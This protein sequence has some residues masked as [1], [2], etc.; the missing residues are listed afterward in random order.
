MK[1]QSALLPD[2]D[3]TS[4]MPEALFSDLKDPRYLVAAFLMGEIY[5]RLSNVALF[6]EMIQKLRTGQIS[7]WKW[8]G[9]VFQLV[10]DQSACTV[11]DMEALE[12][13]DL[14]TVVSM[15]HDDLLNV[16]Q[17][18]RDYVLGFGLPTH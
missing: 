12:N 7:G 5:L 15:S 10:I 13:E 8:S 17:E 3:T 4:P 18:W 6:T 1:T 16:L 11:T 9:N 2:F 14:T